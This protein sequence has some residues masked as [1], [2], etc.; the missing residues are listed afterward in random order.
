MKRNSALTGA[1]GT[2]FVASMLAFRNIHAAVTVGNAPYVDLIAGSVDGSASVT[3]QVKTTE[4]AVRL[5]GR[6]ENRKPHHYEWDV[7]RKSALA[8]NPELM[9]A[10]VDLKRMEEQPDVF[11]VPSLTLTECFAR[12]GEL[13]RWRYHPSIEEAEMSKNEWKI[14]ENFLESGNEV[15]R[16]DRR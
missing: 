8:N 5:R 6:G 13:K 10:F 9:F 14:I 3:I 12:F 2:Y 15:I 11:I 1:C 7:G 4:W 16:D